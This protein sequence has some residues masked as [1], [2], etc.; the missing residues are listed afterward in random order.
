[1]GTQQN[2]FALSPPHTTPHALRGAAL[3][4]ML[5]AICFCALA[6]TSACATTKPVT[7]PQEE[8]TAQKPPPV[9]FLRRKDRERLLEQQRLAAELATNPQ[10]GNASADAQRAAMK[11]NNSGTSNVSG[12]TIANIFDLPSTSQTPNAAPLPLPSGVGDQAIIGVGRDQATVATL[13]QYD[14]A[15]A[16]QREG[17]HVI[18]TLQVARY[19]LLDNTRPKPEEL[20]SFRQAAEEAVLQLRAAGDEAY[21][22]HGVAG[23][24]VTVGLFE[25]AD[26]VTTTKNADGSNAQLP[27]PYESA[28]LMAARAKF[29]HNL[30]NG[31]TLEVRTKGSKDPITQPSFVVGVP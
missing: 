22:Y 18:Y 14:L 30:V 26:Y 15:T 23:S 29:P 25:E 16:K 20:A 24:T 5:C 3:S 31:Q 12:S 21:F 28:R 4:F 6:F 8:S 19:G 10:A 27:R 11:K 7:K 17:P 1:M 2:N 9:L 13:I